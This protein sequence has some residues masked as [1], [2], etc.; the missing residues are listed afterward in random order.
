MIW[1][2]NDRSFGGS[3]S[4]TFSHPIDKNNNKGQFWIAVLCVTIIIQMFTHRVNLVFRPYTVTSTSR[5][6][7]NIRETKD[8]GLKIP[9]LLAKLEVNRTE[10]YPFIPNLS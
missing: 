7:N 10:A 1:E 8:N 4:E 9:V 3:S 6:N 5:N 2:M